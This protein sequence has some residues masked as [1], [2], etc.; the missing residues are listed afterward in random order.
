MANDDLLDELWGYVTNALKV[1]CDNCIFCTKQE[2]SDLEMEVWE[3]Y[4]DSFVNEQSTDS[5]HTLFVEEDRKS[6][7][8][9]NLDVLYQMNEEDRYNE[10]AHEVAHAIEFH[11]FG[12]TNHDKRWEDIHKCMG[13]NGLRGHT[14]FIDK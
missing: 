12:I 8:E 7:I 3:G 9:C 14:L 4:D 13:G 10:M 1:F 6:W 5:A 11:L 2:I